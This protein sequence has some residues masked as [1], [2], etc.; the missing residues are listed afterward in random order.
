MDR[1][2]Y[3]GKKEK[4]YSKEEGRLYKVNCGT[5]ELKDP[6]SNVCLEAALKKLRRMTG[7]PKKEE[8]TLDKRFNS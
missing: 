2:H 8:D 4:Q 1:T 7:F 5:I 3:T 6:S